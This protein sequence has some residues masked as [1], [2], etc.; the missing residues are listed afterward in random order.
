FR[1]IGPQLVAEF[2]GTFAFVFFGAA[3]VLAS[4]AGGA[5]AL[6]DATGVALIAIALA[7]GLIL[8]AAICAF[9]HIARA[10]GIVQL[11]PAVSLA[12]VLTGAQTLIK[13]ISFIVVQ[14]FAAA[15]AAGVL[16]LL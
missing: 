4:G 1:R 16:A 12:L 9:S 14:L 15:S 10:R 11:N 3:A 8:A 6:A 5:G 13:A 2:L 7:H